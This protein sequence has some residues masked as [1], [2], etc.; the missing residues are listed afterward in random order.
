MS[1]NLIFE[2]HLFDD[3]DEERCDYC[4]SPLDECACLD[5]ALGPDGQCAKAGSEE[6]DWECPNSHGPLYCGSNAW[7][8]RHQKLP[9]DGCECQDC[10]NAR[11]SVA[12]R[13]T[14]SGE[15]DG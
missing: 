14:N 13:P 15:D 6:C 12:T 8:L 2:D 7:H 11:R 10:L 5:F 9:V 4:G 1:G 3:D